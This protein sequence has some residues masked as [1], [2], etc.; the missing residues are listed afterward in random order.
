MLKYLVVFEK[1]SNGWGAYVPDLPG[2]IA[3]GETKSET[4]QLIYEAI[5]LH[6]EE[7]TKNGEKI[8]EPL[9]EAETMTFNDELIKV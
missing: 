3:G 7:M 4:E 1:S 8:P 5:E 2:C 9:V 6:L